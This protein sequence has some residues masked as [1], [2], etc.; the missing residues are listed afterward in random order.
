MVKLNF[1]VYQSLDYTE[2][3]YQL[4]EYSNEFPD[5]MSLYQVEELVAERTK[6]LIDYIVTRDNIIDITWGKYFSDDIISKMEITIPSEKVKDL[7]NQ[8]NISHD[9]IELFVN[10]PGIGAVV[11]E[12]DGITFFFHTDEKD[13]HQGTPHIHLKYQGEE[14]RVDL[15]TISIMDKKD[16]KNPGKRKIALK[17]IKQNQS[18]LINY[19]NKVAIKHESCKFKMELK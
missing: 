11:G 17:C 18:D 19:Y 12:T 1:K 13:V 4:I 8:F 3:N 15:T 7:D 6:I 5:D 16:F 9:I 2:D 10:F 14:Y